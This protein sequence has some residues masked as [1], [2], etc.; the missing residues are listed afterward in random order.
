MVANGNNDASMTLAAITASF[1]RRESIKT[2]DNT[3]HAYNIF[4]M[5]KL[6]R[7]MLKHVK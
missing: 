7:N 6:A 3:R 1:D 2:V 4:D 5:S